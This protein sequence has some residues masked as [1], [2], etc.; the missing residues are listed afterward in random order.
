MRLAH[1]LRLSLRVIQNDPQAAKPLAAI[2][3][4]I[5]RKQPHD[6]VVPGEHLVPPIGQNHA[7]LGIQD[8]A[9]ANFG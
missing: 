5:A 3:K 1:G 4:R 2:N 9:F 8:H 7:Q 6:P